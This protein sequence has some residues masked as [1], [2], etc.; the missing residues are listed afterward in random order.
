[1]NRDLAALAD[2]EFDVVIVGGGIYG[3]CAARDAALRGLKVALIDRGDFGGETSHNSLKLIHGG[4]R[5]IQHFDLRRMRQ[6]VVE[7]RIWLTAAPHLVRPVQFVNPTYGRST[8]SAAA[9]WVALKVHGVV[10]FD[11]NKGVPVEN[12]IPSGR[13]ISAGEFRQVL[14]DLPIPGLNGGAFWYDGQML[15]S[16]RLLLECVISA[17]EHGAVVANYVEAVEVLERRNRVCGVRVQDGLSGEK[18]D[19]TGRVTINTCG[20]WIDVLRSRGP[21][22]LRPNGAIPLTKSIN[23]VTRQ[24]T[25]D[26][27]YGVISQQRSDSLVDSGRRMFF[28]TPWR[29]LSVVGTT[30]EQFDGNPDDCSVSE[31]EL[32]AFLD[33]FN[34]VCPMAELDLSDIVYCHCGLTPG[35]EPTHRDAAGRARQS[36]IINHESE[37]GLAGLFSVISVKYTTARLVA[38]KVMDMVMTSLS[39]PVAVRLTRNSALPGAHDYPGHENLER[40][41]IS[42]GQCRKMSAESAELLAIN[43]G[44]RWNLVIE[45]NHE[46]IAECGDSLFRLIGK[47]AVLHEMAVRLE[48]VVFR[49]TDFAERGVLSDA[50]LKWCA[51]M[52]A[53]NLG[54]TDTQKNEEIQST[55]E[56]LRSAYCTVE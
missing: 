9:F 52:M 51:G 24:I 32:Q 30:H 5:Y 10:G 53:E 14:P 20:P 23:V 41:I 39:R 44:T 50:N 28:A 31:Q 43:Y 54:W 3:A 12:L 1:M 29:G 4:M 42:S 8:R 16:N 33:E 21:K 56:K 38:E 36:I 17:V 40:E 27:A 35:D 26:Y 15:N 47:Y 13:I 22:R 18:F 37:N 6:S 19:I 49:R 11:R 46:R 2:A 45:R 55:Y 7:R 48:D 34:S 25:G